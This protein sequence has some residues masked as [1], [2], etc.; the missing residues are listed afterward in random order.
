MHRHQ[1]KAIHTMKNQANMTPTKETHNVPV[2]EPKEMEI[3]KLADKEFK[4]IA[5]K[6]LNEMQENTNN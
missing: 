3:C 2:S 6:K 5:L 1:H 4:V